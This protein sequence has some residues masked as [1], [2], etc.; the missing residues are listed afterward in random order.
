M[1]RIAALILAVTV[2]T[3]LFVILYSEESWNPNDV[4]P[5]ATP[6]IETT[7]DSPRQYVERPA[8]VDASSSRTDSE[9]QLVVPANNKASSSQVEAAEVVSAYDV[10]FNDDDP[11]SPLSQV[12][13][14]FR[15][16]PRNESWASAMED[17]IRGSIV[18]TEATT[19]IT[20]EYVECRSTI[21]KV[22]GYMPS[23]SI[24]PQPDPRDIFLEQFGEGWWHG[25]PDMALRQHSYQDEGIER[26]LIIIA[27]RGV[28]GSMA[29]P[30][31]S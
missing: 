8:S 15:A 16:Q 3:T 10:A 5:G 4:T 9:S 21:C 13:A 14:L 12:H 27:N 6:I 7:V 26:F 24:E 17:G 22:A 11:S 28:M 2:P 1:R 19:G 31:P 20:I 29:I 18:Q 30:D 23:V 25:E